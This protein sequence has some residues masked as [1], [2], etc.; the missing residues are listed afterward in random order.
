MQQNKFEIDPN[1]QEEIEMNEVWEYVT[2][3]PVFSHEPAPAQP[4]QATN[5][6]ELKK[7]DWNKDE[8]KDNTPEERSNKPSARSPVLTIPNLLPTL[9]FLSLIAQAG[10]VNPDLPTIT[11]TGIKHPCDRF[12]LEGGH[13]TSSAFLV[14]D[15]SIQ[16][17]ETEACFRQLS[18]TAKTAIPCLTDRGPSTCDEFFNG[19]PFQYVD[20]TVSREDLIKRDALKNAAAFFSAIVA[21]HL[22]GD[23]TTKTDVLKIID[24]EI[25]IREKQRAA[26]SPENLWERRDNNTIMLTFFI[27]ILEEIRQK[28]AEVNIGIPGLLK[29]EMKRIKSEIDDINTKIDPQAASD[30]LDRDHDKQ[31]PRIVLPKNSRAAAA[32]FNRTQDKRPPDRSKATHFKHHHR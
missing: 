9:V 12:S 1:A 28:V 4:P 29:M 21:S 13:W 11:P 32:F 17:E 25:K 6:R 2:G 22:K 3:L 15:E 26:S 14:I 31:I 19:R 27:R 20:T 10:K 24:N 30:R 5:K 16:P 7:M 23:A 8:L 18:I